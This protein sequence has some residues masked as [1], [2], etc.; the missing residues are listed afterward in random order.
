MGRNDGLIWMLFDI[1]EIFKWNEVEML[2]LLMVG[3][4]QNQPIFSSQIQNQPFFFV[5]TIHQ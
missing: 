4:F 5:H 3:V 1:I 2:L